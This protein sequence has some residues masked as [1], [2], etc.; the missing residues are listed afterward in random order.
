M[1]KTPKV[2]NDKT[3]E[4]LSLI[5]KA[6]LK[7]FQKLHCLRQLVMP[8]FLYTASNSLEVESEANKLD[9]KMGLVVKKA[10]HLPYSFPHTH[11]W[12]PARCGGLGLLQLQRV[13]QAVQLKALARLIRLADPCVDKLFTLVLAKC[14][15]R[16][17]AQL[18]EV[19]DGITDKAEIASA[20]KKG[21]LAW[22]KRLQGRYNNKDLFAHKTQFTANAWVSHDSKLMRDGD[23]IRALRM[24][25][26][27]Y[28]TRTLSNRHSSDPAD[29]L[30]RRCRMAPET[31]YHILQTCKS[32][33]LPWTERHNFLVR[34]TE[35][36]VHE[37][38]PTV[39]VTRE[40]LFVAPSGL[41]LRP[42]RVV[43]DGNSIHIVDFVVCWNT[44][45]AI[46]KNTCD[47]KKRK[48]TCPKPLFPGKSVQV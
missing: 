12:M 16:R 41:R 43:E 33:D 46:L 25:T 5:Q 6:S 13:A 45:V 2:E 8:A 36:M 20:I 47:L 10:L 21:S 38:N 1:N 23:R 19:P 3:M 34:Q 31:V 39:H 42:D 32:M 26:N 9:R 24:L 15:H 48:Y 29:R 18:F 28:P 35:R 40:K 14:H 30:C 7:P 44:N 4:L 27:L 22:W 17:L 37:R 11:L